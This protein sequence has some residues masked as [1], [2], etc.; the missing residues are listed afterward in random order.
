LNYWPI[1]PPALCRAAG[2]RLAHYLPKPVLQWIF[3]L[4]LVLIGL[5]MVSG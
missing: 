2:I 3:A 5:P 4:V 1:S